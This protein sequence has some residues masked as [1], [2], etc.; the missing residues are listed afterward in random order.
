[1][2]TARTGLV[3]LAVLGLA[4]CSDDMQTSVERIDLDE[5]PTMA[6]LDNAYIIEAPA[7]TDFGPQ[8]SYLGGESAQTLSYSAQLE[9]AGELLAKEDFEGF[10]FVRFKKL[11]PPFVAGGVSY[12]TRTNM[13][14]GT[15]SSYP[16]T[17]NV[18][19]NNVWTPVVASVVDDAAPVRALGFDVTVLGRPTD[20][21]NIEIRTDAQ[22]YAFND[23]NV[24]A[25]PDSRFIGF[26]AP[27]DENITGFRLRS[28]APGSGPCL[29]NVM[30]VTGP[31]VITVTVTSP[32]VMNV[33]SNGV[34]TV[35]VLSDDDF[36]ATTLDAGT[37]AFGPDG[38]PEAHETGHVDDVDDDGD[39]DMVLHFWIQET[40]IGCPHSEAT[41]SAETTDGTPVEGTASFT[42]TNG[43]RGH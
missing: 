4:A 41:L 17:S 7:S 1:M 3:L 26:A 28:Q 42:T 29:D 38:A 35:A 33:N 24:P 21:V 27:A 22:T 39:E 40:G 19:C 15:A 2:N 43:C 12:E 31:S 30:L 36:D 37:A 14:I 8:R 34:F 11:P 23:L 13:V 9:S 5:I 25:G 6:E 18:M 20:P 16:V 10:G 32:S